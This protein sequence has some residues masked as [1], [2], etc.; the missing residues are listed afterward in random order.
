MIRTLLVAFALVSTLASASSQVERAVTPAAPGPARLEV[1]AELLSGAS[2]GLKDLR[3]FDSTGREIEYLLVEPPAAT[4]KWSTGRV[5]P[6]RATKET[7]GFEADFGR[8]DRIE[9]LRLEGM[10]PPF[11]K[12]ATVEGSGDRSRWTLLATATVFD[13]PDERLRLVEIAFTAGS[14]RYIRVTWDDRASA[15]IALPSAVRARLGEAHGATQ[16]VR[17]PL[18]FKRRGSEPGTSRYAIVRPA[19]K[20]AFDAVELDVANG[21]VLREAR[22]TESRLRAGRASPVVLGSATLRKVNG[23]ASAALAI[24]VSPPEGRELELVVIDGS[25]APLE[26]RSINARFPAQPWIYFESNGAPLIARYGDDRA[27]SP[28]YDLEA[29]RGRIRRDTT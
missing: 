15:P 7:S 26:L 20:T 2:A 9:V 19:W 23:E 4:A 14:Y 1:D 16:H 8:P 6:V 11:M 24:P 13:L 5:L 17:V 29:Q 27:A 25:S 3:L 22:L 10:Q 18:K 12:R 21:N 28:R